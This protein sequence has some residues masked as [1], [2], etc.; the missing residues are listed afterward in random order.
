MSKTCH[1][2]INLFRRVLSTD[3][4]CQLQIA[5]DKIQLVFES[6]SHTDSYYSTSKNRYYKCIFKK[7]KNKSM[8]FF[9][10]VNL[11]YTILNVYITLSHS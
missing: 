2:K 4:I 6:K 5:L 7:K 3:E 9:D 11:K 10:K 8:L 1:F